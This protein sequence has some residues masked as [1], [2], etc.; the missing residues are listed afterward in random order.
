MLSVEVV[1]RPSRAQTTLS[2]VQAACAAL[3]VAGCAAA[4]GP[5]PYR[6]NTAPAALSLPEPAP[7][8]EV[9]TP[10]VSE[11]DFVVRVVVGKVGC[12]GSLIRADRVLTAH[13]CVAARDGA[14]RVL[15]R[16]Q[17]LHLLHGTADEAFDRSIDVHIS[18]L[19]QKLGDDARNPRLLKTIRGVGYMLTPDDK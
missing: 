12:S 13:H 19:R 3:T 18:R 17:L 2:I 9:L 1:R 15:D 7:L 11:D 5:P 14:G 4:L 16:E 10:I 6:A 8:G